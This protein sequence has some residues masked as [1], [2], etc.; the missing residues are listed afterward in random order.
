MGKN[1]TEDMYLN[2]THFLGHL[3]EDTDVASEI[4]NMTFG[5]H[6]RSTCVKLM[7]MAS[8]KETV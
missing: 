8:K 4:A 3:M 2:G 5:L 7:L 1:G 6:A